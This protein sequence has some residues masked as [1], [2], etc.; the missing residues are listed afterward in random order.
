M[1]L[2]GAVQS[3]A[4]KELVAE[5][6]KGV[7]GVRQIRDHLVL[8]IQRGSGFSAIVRTSS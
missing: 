2:T 3:R 7:K 5:V 6:V 4:E 8:R 1:T